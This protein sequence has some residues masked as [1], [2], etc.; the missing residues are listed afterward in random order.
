[1]G[2]CGHKCSSR[3]SIPRL[4][5]NILAHEV[6][7][8]DRKLAAECSWDKL[9]DYIVWGM[10]TTEK[11]A[12]LLYWLNSHTFQLAAT[13]CA[14]YRQIY[15]WILVVT[16]PVSPQTFTCTM[17]Y[18]AILFTDNNGRVVSCVFVQHS[19]RLLSGSSTLRSYRVPS[20]I[21]WALWWER[22]TARGLVWSAVAFV[23]LCWGFL[24][25]GNVEKSSQTLIS[26]IMSLA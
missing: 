5:C 8:S 22:T 21:P 25:W 16:P 6:I 10:L 26:D 9:E 14:K 1:M 24:W 3:L 13:Y 7:S 17:L 15:W 19:C 11:P 18:R 20:N 2:C 12:A 23:E 4:A